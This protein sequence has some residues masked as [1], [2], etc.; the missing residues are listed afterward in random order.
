MN[1]VRIHSPMVNRLD[2]LFQ[3]FAGHDF[4][5]MTSALPVGFPPLNIWEDKDSYT[6]KRNC[7]ASPVSRSTSTCSV[8]S[9]HQRRAI[10][11]GSYRGDT[12]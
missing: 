7:Q 10:K 9:H 6:L 5:G 11:A 2:Q 3:A 4:P 1:R 8:L 12:S